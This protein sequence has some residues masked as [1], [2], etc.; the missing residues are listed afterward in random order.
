[1]VVEIQEGRNG[2]FLGDGKVGRKA[3]DVELVVDADEVGKARC[4]NGQGAQGLVE[5]VNGTIFETLIVGEIDVVFDVGDDVVEVAELGTLNGG[6]V[7]DGAPFEVEAV[8]EGVEVAG[9]AA[10]VTFGS[11]R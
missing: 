4:G 11:G 3:G 2:S 8:F 9:L 10:A 1:M 6:G 7:A 5:F